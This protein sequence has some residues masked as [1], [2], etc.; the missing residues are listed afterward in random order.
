M[1]QNKLE[2]HDTSKGWSIQIRPTIYDIKLD[3]IER[4]QQNKTCHKQW[5]KDMV[6][7]EEILIISYHHPDSD[8]Y[9]RGGN[10]EMSDM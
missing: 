10:R 3:T 6:D 1:I 8:E 9:Y 2:L 7:L 5:L 4:L